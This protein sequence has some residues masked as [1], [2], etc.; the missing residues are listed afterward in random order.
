MSNSGASAHFN[1]FSI[2]HDFTIKSFDFQIQY[3]LSLFDSWSKAM[4]SISGFEE[5]GKNIQDKFRYTFDSELKNRLKRLEFCKSLS[6][7]IRS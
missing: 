3:G 5:N 4:E 1:L 6:D 2:Y 7:F